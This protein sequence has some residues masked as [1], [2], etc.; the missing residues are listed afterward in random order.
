[1]LPLVLLSLLT[2]LLV[3]SGVSCRNKTF[4]GRQNLVDEVRGFF[5]TII[6]P[7]VSL[8]THVICKETSEIKKIFGSDVALLPSLNVCLYVL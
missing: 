2:S 3:A 5:Q 1:L 7:F 6:S 4:I 8:S